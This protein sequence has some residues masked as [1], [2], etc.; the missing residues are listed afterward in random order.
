VQNG[1]QHFQALVPASDVP[2]V[3]RRLC[4]CAAKGLNCRCD[5]LLQE[6]PFYHMSVGAPS[7]EQRFVR[8]QRAIEMEL[9]RPRWKA[10]LAK[11]PYHLRTIEASSTPPSIE[12]RLG[13]STLSTNTDGELMGV[14]PR[15][16][17]QP[18]LRSEAARSY[19]LELLQ[20]PPHSPSAWSHFGG[21]PEC[22]LTLSVSAAVL[23]SFV[24]SYG[25]WVVPDDLIDSL[26]RVVHVC[27]A[28]TVDAL[29]YRC[30]VSGKLNK[31]SIIGDPTFVG[32][33]IN[34]GTINKQP[35]NQRT[36]QART[37]WRGSSVVDAHCS[38]L[39][40]CLRVQ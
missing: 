6:Q 29:N 34:D 25:G 10:A 28:V 31:V 19:T 12:T 22:V 14:F 35:C 33:Q 3:A 4:E 32:P 20:L 5:F 9:S 17:Q 8:Q 7:G 26:Q 1:A 37:H 13:S 2:A 40:V 18:M 21:P 11:M 23:C 30:S 38:S 15:S 16:R 39:R 24:T 27:T 36:A